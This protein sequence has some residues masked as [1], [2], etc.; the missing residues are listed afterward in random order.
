MSM[1]S[2][3]FGNTICQ[4][5]PWISLDY[6]VHVQLA[7]TS[8]VVVLHVAIYLVMIFWLVNRKVH[9]TDSSIQSA[10]V[11]FDL[12]ALFHVQFRT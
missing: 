6:H 2:A 9:D 1:S 5:Q 8:Y 4:L 7:C 11:A 3:L 10:D 12:K